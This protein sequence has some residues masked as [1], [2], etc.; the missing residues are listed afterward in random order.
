[1]LHAIANGGIT[2]REE[3]ADGERVRAGAKMKAENVGKKYLWLSQQECNI[4]VHEL[5]MGRA[6]VFGDSG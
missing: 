6:N 3:G 4:W 1:V 2:D 5:G